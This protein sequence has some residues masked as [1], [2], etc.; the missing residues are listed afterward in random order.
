MYKSNDQAAT[1]LGLS[2]KAAMEVAVPQL[3]ACRHVAS[4]RGVANPMAAGF[5][6]SQA[7]S[8]LDKDMEE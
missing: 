2:P 1:R 7:V 3:E 8:E 6:Q 5:A 4:V